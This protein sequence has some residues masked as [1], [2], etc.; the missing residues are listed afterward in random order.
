[1]SNKEYWDLLDADRIPTGEVF[2]RSDTIQPGQL[3]TVVHVCIFNENNEMLI[4]HRSESKDNWPGRWDVSAGGSALTGETSRRAAERETAEELGIVLDLTDQ[5]PYFTVNFDCGF[6]DYY[7]VHL[8]KLNPE[9]LVLQESEL[10]GVK[11][12]C[13]DEILTLLDEHKFVPCKKNLIRLLFDYA[14]GTHF[15][16]KTENEA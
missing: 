15:P 14:A 4:Q 6:D 9:N 12:A 5:R 8:P 10:Q 1:M 13:M 11:F 2:C 16:M 3:H 7:I